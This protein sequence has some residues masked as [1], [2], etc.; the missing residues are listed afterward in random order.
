VTFTWEGI[1]EKRRPNN[2]YNERECGYGEQLV[3][4]TA[5]HTD[6]SSWGSQM[7]AVSDFSGCSCA[8][9]CCRMEFFSPHTEDLRS[10]PPPGIKY[11]FEAEGCKQYYT[12]TDHA[13]QHVFITADELY[14]E[15]EPEP[16]PEPE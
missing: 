9:V 5:V 16:E 10:K 15:S 12:V 8:R 11:T 7:G 13:A 6:T 14:V 4:L 1:Q 2:G 3:S